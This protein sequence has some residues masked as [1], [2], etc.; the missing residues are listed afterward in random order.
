MLSVEEARRKFWADYERKRC[1]CSRTEEW[2]SYAQCQMPICFT[3]SFCEKGSKQCER[4]SC[5]LLPEEKKS[6]VCFKCPTPEPCLCCGTPLFPEHGKAGIKTCSSCLAKE[7]AQKQVDEAKRWAEKAKREEEAAAL[8]L[9]KGR[10]C[11]FCLMKTATIMK[12]SQCGGYYF[13]CRY[14]A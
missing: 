5:F 14:C 10:E 1:T 8:E 2:S 9:K 3:C 11:G 12:K 4:C 13:S 7:A 6:S